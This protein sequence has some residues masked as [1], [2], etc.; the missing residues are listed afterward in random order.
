M[1]VGRLTDCE[2]QGS[3]LDWLSVATDYTGSNW[4][5]GRASYISDDAPAR[6]SE[7]CRDRFPTLVAYHREFASA[8]AQGR[9]QLPD[10]AIVLCG[11]PAVSALVFDCQGR[12]VVELAQKVGVKAPVGLLQEER[13]AFLAYEVAHPELHS[14][15]LRPSVQL[16][17]T[18]EFFLAVE[19]ADAAVIVLAKVEHAKA[20]VVITAGRIALRVERKG[21][22]VADRD[23]AGYAG[24]LSETALGRRAWSHG[25]M[26][27]LLSIA[28][29][30]TIL[31]CF[32]VV[33]VATSGD[34]SSDII[35][36]ASNS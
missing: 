2:C 26:G 32:A 14:P 23:T 5:V 17:S 28:V 27:A 10:V 8:I 29:I 22:V 20:T 6:R 7:R 1:T 15:G 35:E 30:L 19:V 31:G 25:M 18:L 11:F 13:A 12:A 4:R 21:V 24:E 3:L 36:G 16:A 34:G 9:P 33:G